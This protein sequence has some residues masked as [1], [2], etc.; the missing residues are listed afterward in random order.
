MTDKSETT[1]RQDAEIKR[2]KDC[3]NAAMYSFS[4]IITGDIR[5]K[6]GTMELVD[7]P[8]CFIA[9]EAISRIK[10]ELSIL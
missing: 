9:R 4:D 7:G 3:L 1:K 2:L 8:V 6:P 5:R 10:Q